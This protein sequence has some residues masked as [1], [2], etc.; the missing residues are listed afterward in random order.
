MPAGQ[1]SSLRR[2]PPCRAAAHAAGRAY[3][4]MKRCSA[5]PGCAPPARL[6]IWLPRRV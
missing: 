5:M 4:A 6:G 3:S 2:T 1:V